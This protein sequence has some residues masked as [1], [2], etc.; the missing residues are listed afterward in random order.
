MDNLNELAARLITLPGIIN[1]AQNSIIDLMEESKTFSNDIDRLEAVIKT[2]IG[3]I[4]DVAG[5][6]LYTNAESRDAAFIE[7]SAEN[8]ELTDLRTELAGLTKAIQLQRNE[9]EMLGNEQRNARAILYFF[10]GGER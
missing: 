2:E 9:V 3:S 6:K 7:R 4:T 8:Q 10:G 5:K 1:T